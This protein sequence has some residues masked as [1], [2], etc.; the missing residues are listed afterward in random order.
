MHISHQPSFVS[1]AIKRIPEAK[2]K[3][4]LGSQLHLLH[5]HCC[6]C[7]VMRPP[8]HSAEIMAMSF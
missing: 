2:E 6:M 5:A 1:W 3:I 4:S 7:D 8:G